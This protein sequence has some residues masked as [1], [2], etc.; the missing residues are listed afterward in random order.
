MALEVEVEIERRLDFLCQQID[1]LSLGNTE[2]P[3]IYTPSGSE[4]IYIWCAIHPCRKNCDGCL[5][6]SPQPVKLD[7]PRL[8]KIR[9]QLRN[10]IT[11]SRTL[12]DRIR[13]LGLFL[14]S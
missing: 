1:N 9:F 6:Y 10:I 13:F 3:C 4:R 7:P 8:A 11:L 12:R 5:D 2:M 14:I